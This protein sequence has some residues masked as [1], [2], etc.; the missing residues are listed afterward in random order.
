MKFAMGSP[1]S[2]S[3]A[4]SALPLPISPFILSFS[5]FSVFPTLLQLL[6]FPP[7]PEDFWAS[8]TPFGWQV[9]AS[10]E[11]WFIFQWLKFVERSAAGWSWCWRVFRKKSIFAFFLN[12]SDCFARCSCTSCLLLKANIASLPGCSRLYPLEVSARLDENSSRST[13][14][15]MWRWV[16]FSPFSILCA[17]FLGFSTAHPAFF[18]VRAGD[19]SIFFGFNFPVLFSILVVLFEFLS[20]FVAVSTSFHHFSRRFHCGYP[21]FSNY[22]L[23]Y[24]PCVAWFGFTCPFGSFRSPFLVRFGLSLSSSCRTFDFALCVLV[25]LICDF[26]FPWPF[27]CA[28]GCCVVLVRV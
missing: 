25:S 8:S 1:Y 18:P 10:S 9:G 4:V 17:Y 13:L 7:I 14:F 23:S 20:D 15:F 22:L 5:P 2:C 24:H 28:C 27:M 6:L 11:P 3:P 12:F 16:N 26:F 21:F 19:F